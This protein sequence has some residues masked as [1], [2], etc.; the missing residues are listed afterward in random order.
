MVVVVDCGSCMCKAGFAGDA[1]PR[2][3]FPSV[4]E[5]PRPGVMAGALA[6][7]TRD[8][9]DRQRRRYVFP[10]QKGL[11]ISWDYV[12]RLWHHLFYNELL[13]AP[14]E[15]P[16]LLTEAPVTPKADRERTTQIMF[17]TFDLPA[18]YV[19]CASVLSLYASGRLTGLVVECGH[20]VSHAVPVW[21]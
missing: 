11:V 15:H 18:L 3:V 17:E 13:V 10:I 5:R 1:A 19:A 14:E 4:V 2:A 8:Q 20:E 9:A 12:E 6:G 7:R 16:V 21:E